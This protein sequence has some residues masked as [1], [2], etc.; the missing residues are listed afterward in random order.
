MV[1]VTLAVLLVAAVMNLWFIAISLAKP[2]WSLFKVL[3]LGRTC[4]IASAIELFIVVV[5]AVLFSRSF[6][7]NINLSIRSLC[8]KN[9]D[10]V[11]IFIGICIIGAIVSFN[12]EPPIRIIYAEE[13]GWQAFYRKNKPKVVSQEEAFRFAWGTIRF[14]SLNILIFPIGCL[15]NLRCIFL[16]N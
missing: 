5:V 6:Y 10:I 12:L 7:E 14:C 8:W 4:L 13:A 11:A 15:Y 3:T 1:W 9:D 2:K 16:V